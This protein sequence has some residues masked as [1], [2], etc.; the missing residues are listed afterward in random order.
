MMIRIGFC[1]SI[2]RLFDHFVGVK[3]FRQITVACLLTVQCFLAG[4]GGPQELREFLQEYRQL[5]DAGDVQA[6]IAMYD[7]TGVPA[8]HRQQ[9]MRSLAEESRYPIRAVEWRRVRPADLESHFAH[10]GL[11]PSIPPRWVVSIVL[12]T[13]DSLSFSQLV[14]VTPDGLR[15]VGAAE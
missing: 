13:E 14:G 6:L 1:L 8:N 9:L 15:W 11:Q 5:H 3:I 7:W 2:P 4:C 12:D 10:T